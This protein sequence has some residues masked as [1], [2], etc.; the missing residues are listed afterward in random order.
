MTGPDWPSVP[1]LT[2]SWDYSDLPDG[3]VIGRECFLERRSSLDRIRG[4]RR[5][6]LTLG[7]RVAV[8]TWT[9]FSI[10]GGG[11]V[12]VGSDTILVGALFMCAEHIRVGQGVVVS[13]NVTI[14]DCDFHPRD[15]ESRRLDAVANAPSGDLKNRPPMTSNPVSI[16][17]GAWIGI[18]AMVLK[19]VRVGTGARVAPG[20]VVTA[21]VPP[22]GY[23][24]GNPARVTAGG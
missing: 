5:P 17:D 24:E 15:P 9:T 7:D 18:G 20:A 2:G 16:G 21:D 3:V 13:Y 4:W 8:H 11:R 10:E 14:A 6:A 1:D 23:A 22:G 19:G 12:E